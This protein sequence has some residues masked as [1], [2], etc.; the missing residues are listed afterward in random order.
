MSGEIVFDFLGRPLPLFGRAEID[1]FEVEVAGVDDFACGV[2]EIDES[3][4]GGEV[5]VDD[6]EVGEVADSPGRGS[7]SITGRSGLD[8]G[9]PS[10]GLSLIFA[11]SRRCAILHE[12]QL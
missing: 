3:E 6:F 8:L 4:I 5:G 2:V 7:F 11:S 10:C 9:L 1:D 12:C